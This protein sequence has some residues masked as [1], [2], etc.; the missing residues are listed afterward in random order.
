MLPAE[1][2]NVRTLHQYSD[3]GVLDLQACEL[4]AKEL[5]S[6]LLAQLRSCVPVA[7][8]T[9]QRKVCEDGSE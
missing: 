5:V 7:K 2:R 8:S 4:V 6:L 3:A 9:E 1:T